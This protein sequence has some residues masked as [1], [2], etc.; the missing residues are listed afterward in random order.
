MIYFICELLNKSKFFKYYLITPWVYAIG[1]CGEHISIGNR[2]ARQNHKKLIIIKLNIFKK[3]L[4][5]HI[6]NED[7]FENLELD[8]DYTKTYKIVRSLFTILINIEFVFLRTLVI[9]NDK[10]IK[11]KL[12]EYLRFPQIG[13]KSIIYNDKNF[14]NL[15]ISKNILKIQH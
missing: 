4:K 2:I 10:T 15:K 13:I 8:P 11:V 3:F 12:P 14:F 1:T 7:L 9:I 5:Y 6:C